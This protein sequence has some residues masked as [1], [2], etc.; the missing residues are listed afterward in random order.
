MGGA[1]REVSDAT[2]EILLE[3]AYFEPMGIAQTSKRLGLRSESSARFERGIDPNGV[4]DR[5]GAGD[6]ALRARW[7]RR[8]PRRARSTSTRSRSSAARIHVRTSKVNRLLGTELGDAEVAGRARA[9]RASR[10]RAAATTSRDRADVPARP[11]ARDRHRRGGR[12]P[13]RVR[14]DR[15]HGAASPASRSAGSPPRQRERRAGRRR[16][17]R[18][19]LRRGRHDPARRAGRPRTGRRAA[20]RRRRGGEP[21]ARRGVGAA[22]RDPPRAAARGRAQPRARPHRRRAVR[23]RPRVRSAARRGSAAARRADA[24]RGRAAG[25]GAPAAG[26][27]RPAGRRLRRRST[28]AR[29]AR[30]AL[31]LADWRLEAGG[32]PGL[33]SR[34]AR[35]RRSSTARTI[36]AR[37]RARRRVA[38]RA[39]S[40]TAPVV[41]V[42][43]R[44][45]RLLDGSR[46]DRAF[47]PPSRVPAV[48]D[49][50][51]V[52]ASTRTSRPAR[53][54]AT[55][56]T[57]RRRAPG[58]G[59]PVRRLPLRRARRG[60]E[61]PRV[62]AAVPRAGPHAHRR[63]G[64]RVC[65]QRASTRSSR[66]TAP[67]CAAERPWPFVHRVRPRYA[68][69]D[70]QGVVFNAHWLTYFDEACTRFFEAWGSTRR[71]R[72]SATST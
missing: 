25:H 19:R 40:S 69:V 10:S 66:R 29:G 53:V 71:R 59:A 7:P 11:R 43:A 16:A 50:P 45:R 48:D 46:R 57:R 68:E 34:P 41:G 5:A 55:L 61:E 72:S 1:R 22:A 27:A 21:A 58:G 64:R 9:A 65:R 18:R 20:D 14:L 56:R 23:D 13:G 42:R 28:C 30:D 54:A 44:P 35:R 60:P 26:R 15:P 31:E 63:G 49:R 39:R 8:R 6:G 17:R 4:A 36:G 70:A 3:S 24:S 32:A 33:R 12:P 38:R 62:R 2:T 52:R 37:R 67:S 47:R 51:R